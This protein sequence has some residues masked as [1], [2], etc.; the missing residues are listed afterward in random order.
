MFFWITVCACIQFDCISKYCVISNIY[1]RYVMKLHDFQQC[2]PMVLWLSCS[3]SIWVV[4]FL[5][6]NVYRII[7]F[8]FFLKFLKCSDNIFNIVILKI[9]LSIVQILDSV[10]DIINQI[11]ILSMWWN[12]SDS[13][14]HTF[15][16]HRSD[17]KSWIILKFVTK[18]IMNKFLNSC[19]YKYSHSKYSCKKQCI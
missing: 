5:N 12:R 3:I 16:Q 13:I 1:F 9:H 17:K 14:Y 10:F 8:V 11:N 18:N 15:T 7:L 19:K 2:L 4:I 6:R